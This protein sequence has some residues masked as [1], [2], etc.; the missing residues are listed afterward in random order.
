MVL[1]SAGHH[2][3][4]D[5][6]GPG[7]APPD[8][9]AQSARQTRNQ[10]IGFPGERAGG[11]FVAFWLRGGRVAAGMNTSVWDM[12][13]HVQA[14]ARSRQAVEVAAARRR[15]MLPDQ[16][17]APAGSPADP[18]TRDLVFD[19]FPRRDE[20]PLVQDIDGDDGPA[21]DGRP[22]TPA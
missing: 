8:P 11:Q 21:G 3:P 4:G 16:D 6:R 17:L 19:H 13:D 14:L 12:N 1:V 22:Q 15:G 20:D 9:A 18:V 2:S 10:E 5:G 7:A